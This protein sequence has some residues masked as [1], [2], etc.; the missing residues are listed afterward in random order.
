MIGAAGWPQFCIVDHRMMT[1]WRPFSLP[2]SAAWTR[3]LWAVA[4]W[5]EAR[6]VNSARSSALP[7]LTHTSKSQ[8]WPSLV[9]NRATFHCNEIG[10][11]HGLLRSLDA[12]QW[13]ACL[14][15][16][17]TNKRPGCLLSCGNAVWFCWPGFNSLLYIFF[18]QLYFLL[19]L[20]INISC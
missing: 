11:W 13:P 5:D 15:M 4:Q 6:A 14:L 20:V 19:Q 8:R 1:S 16:S 12:T 18:I 3:W 2:W 17:P 9:G 10:H 7:Y